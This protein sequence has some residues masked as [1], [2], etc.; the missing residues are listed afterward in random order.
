[1]PSENDMPVAAPFGLVEIGG[2][3]FVRVGK[4]LVPRTDRFLFLRENVSRPDD[5][6]RIARLCAISRSSNAPWR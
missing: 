1:M 4:A 6:E 2:D 3:V 5:A